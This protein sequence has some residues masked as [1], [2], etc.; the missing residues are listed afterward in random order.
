MSL[1]SHSGLYRILLLVTQPR[2]SCGEDGIAATHSVKTQSQKP[3]YK[4]AKVRTV[5]IGYT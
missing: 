1:P 4:Q 3:L 5:Y 2:W